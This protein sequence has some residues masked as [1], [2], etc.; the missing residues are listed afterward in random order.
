MQKPIRGFTLI[1]L[2]VV[3]AIIGILAGIIIVAMGGASD[4]ANDA[5]RKADINQLSKGVMI[6]KTNNPDT[7]LPITTCTIGN[8]CIDNTIF[9]NGSVLKD[10]NGGY[11]TYASADGNDFIITAKLSDNN[12]YSFDSSTGL[13]GETS[14][15]ALVNGTCGTANKTYIYNISNYGTDTFCTTG[16]ANPAS[17]SFPSQGS[18]ISWSCDGSGGGSSATCKALREIA[19]IADWQMNEG[20]GTS[21]INGLGANN[22]IINGATWTVNGGVNRLNFDGT[23]DYINCG[24]DSIFN[25]S[26]FTLSAWIYT[27]DASALQVIIDKSRG[28]SSNGGLMFS[29]R[30][31][32]LE[33]WTGDGVAPSPT[34]TS[35]ANVPINQW[36]HVVG[37]SNGGVATNSMKLYFNG[38]EQAGVEEYFGT[39]LLA[40]TFPVYIG[41]YN[42]TVGVF[43]GMIGDMRIYNKALTQEEVT[44]LHD[45]QKVNY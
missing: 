30:S 34:L 24:N 29:L 22:G 26:A 8:S 15:M 7:L 41:A 16:S 3:I 6:Y 31:G 2:L 45:L 32:K 11:Y 21:I 38:I 20:S 25:L 27:T 40:N 23:N 33:I 42:S 36:I 12:D 35:S 28:S 17:L 19:P 9:G 1:E 18:S 10:P 14:S 13:Y 37:S 44:I 4:S 39:V 43:K 5:R